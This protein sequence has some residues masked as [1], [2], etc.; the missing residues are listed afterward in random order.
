MQTDLFLEK[1]LP[2]YKAYFDIVQP[3]EL[4][5]TTCEAYCSFSSRNEKYVLVKKAQLWVTECFEHVLFLKVSKLDVDALEKAK[6]FLAN[7]AEP[8]L[9]KPKKDHM[10]T[11]LT[12]VLLC[13]DGIEPEAEKELK[14]YNFEKNYLLSIHGWCAAR[15][16]AADLSSERVIFNRK[17][18]E[19]K[20][21]Y[22]SV[23]DSDTPN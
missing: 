9:V 2:K 14:K 7:V 11:Y 23:F 6:L 4:G 18:K 10:Y 17:G 3:F 22:S 1:I 12:L 8:S 13:V 5:G 21:V 16:I 20:K 15:V 19:V